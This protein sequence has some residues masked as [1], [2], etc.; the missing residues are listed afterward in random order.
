[1]DEIS[2]TQTME[3]LRRDM[4]RNGLVMRVCDELEKLLKARSS[5][6]EQRPLKPKVEGSIPSGSSKF[7]RNAYQREYMRKRRAKTVDK[8]PQ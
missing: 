3:K 2:L 7:D 6:V 4:P 1:M 5:T 8:L